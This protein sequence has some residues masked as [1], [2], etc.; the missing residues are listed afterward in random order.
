MLLKQLF[1]RLN[2]GTLPALLNP[3][4]LFGSGTE[5]VR[6]SAKHRLLYPSD[7]GLKNL[8]S[9]R[10][11]RVHVSASDLGAFFNAFYRRNYG[12]IPPTHNRSRRLLLLHG[13]RLHHPKPLIRRRHQCWCQLL[14]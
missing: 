2:Q 14:L 7:F 8:C 13:L 6:E 9:A 4:K 10:S 3:Y 5:F 12:V 1:L 11:L